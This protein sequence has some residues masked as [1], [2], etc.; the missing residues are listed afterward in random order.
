M[1][2]KVRVFRRSPFRF[3]VGGEQNQNQVQGGRG[4]VETL[5]V[6][7]TGCRYLTQCS[8]TLSSK[9]VT[10]FTNAVKN[11][12][13]FE[14]FLDDLPIWGW[15]GE[16]SDDGKVYVYTYHQITIKYNADQVGSYTIK[17]KTRVRLSK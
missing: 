9:D 1:E 4:Q 2:G 11:Q 17:T 15:I 6:L 7:S 8:V 5:R 16:V 13:W 3:R 10:D 12:Y 14:F